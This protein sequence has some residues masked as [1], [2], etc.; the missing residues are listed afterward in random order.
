MFRLVR[1][2]G[3]L[4]L[5]LTPA[6]AHAVDLERNGTQ[7]RV[8]LKFPGL[9]FSEKGLDRVFRDGDVSGSLRLIQDD[10]SKCEPLLKARISA[11]AG[12]GFTSVVGTKKGAK[13]CFVSLHDP[14]RNLYTESYYVYLPACACFSALHLTFGSDGVS[15]GNEISEGLY[16]QLKSK[17]L[18]V[19]KVQ[20]GARGIES[21]S[22]IATTR[23]QPREC[24]A[25]DSGRFEFSCKFIEVGQ[26]NGYIAEPNKKDPRWR[27]IEQYWQPSTDY[28][29][30]AG[31]ACGRADDRAKA[32][33]IAQQ[34]AYAI[35]K[36]LIEG[37]DSDYLSGKL[38]PLGY[39]KTAE[40]FD[41]KEVEAR[42][43][44]DDG[45][46][47]EIEGAI[48]AHCPTTEAER[49]EMVQMLREQADEEAARQRQAEREQRERTTAT[50]ILHNEDKYKLGV[51]FYS[52]TRKNYA[53]PGGNKQ[54]ILERSGTYRLNCRPG[55]KICY[56]AWRDYQTIYWGVGHGRE[57]CSN[58]CLHC[59]EQREI[60]LQHGGPD[61]FP[62]KNGGGGVGVADILNAFGTGLAIGNAL[63]GSGGGYSGGYSGGA[64]P[65]APDRRPS[66]ISGLDD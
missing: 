51:E 41:C 43:A 20:R 61:R 60:T 25:S 13:D 15:R 64:A 11:K 57:G 4:V 24:D 5:L 65:R 38:S 21:Y 45:G 48:L 8:P 46:L 40:G 36:G 56:G 17:G 6:V 63:S 52:M 54:Y 12:E 58:C 49:Q 3:V 30:F 35:V 1:L 47:C 55:E 33:D 53:W 27:K 28:L 26:I 2:L 22:H 50:F 14:D 18:K 34:R 31:V 10:H 62:S 16:T 32:R 23:M 19:S 42:V 59:G 66:G 39:V 44:Q 7:Y 9:T 29:K 37:F